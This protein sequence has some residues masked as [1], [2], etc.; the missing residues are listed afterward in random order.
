MTLCVEYADASSTAREVVTDDA[1]EKMYVSDVQWL[2]FEYAVKDSTCPIRTE[3]VASDSGEIFN[4]AGYETTYFVFCLVRTR[5]LV[6][7]GTHI[8]NARF[9]KKFRV[10][11]TKDLPQRIIIE[12][13]DSIDWRGLSYN[14]ANAENLVNT[15]FDCS[16]IQLVTYTS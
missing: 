2:E 9:L 8:S 13:H 16:R 15:F 3:A 11:V 6:D 1:P 14:G 7:D 4:F 5:A 12:Q 10:D